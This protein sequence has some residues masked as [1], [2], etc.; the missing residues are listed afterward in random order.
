M[1]NAIPPALAAIAQG[2]DHITTAEVA[3]VLTKSPQTIRKTYQEHGHC[4]GIRPVKIGGTNRWPVAAV[5]A[6]LNGSAK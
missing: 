2:R 6:L 5:A 4:Y 3:K 1:Q